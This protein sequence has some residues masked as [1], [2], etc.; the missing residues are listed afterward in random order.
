M[1]RMT[2]YARHRK[3]GSDEV[4]IRP[5]TVKRISVI[6]VNDIAGMRRDTRCYDEVVKAVPIDVA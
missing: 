4:S 6:T 1:R 3:R 5:F 2:G